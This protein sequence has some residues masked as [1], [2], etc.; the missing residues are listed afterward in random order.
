MRTR[1]GR[2]R[3]QALAIRLLL[4]TALVSFFD[5]AFAQAPPPASESD[6]ARAKELFFQGNELRKAGN[7]AGALELYLQSRELAPSVPNT[8]NAAVCLSELGRYDEALEMYERLLA[9]FRD[10][11]DPE[12]KK[13]IAEETARLRAK[14]GSV[15]VSSNVGG[16]LVIDGRPRGKLPLV[17]PVRVL[18]GTRSVRVIKSGYAPFSRDVPVTVGQTVRV[19]AALELLENAGLVK[20]DSVDLA[21][22]EI[23]IDGAR[24][25]R[26]PWE[27]MLQPG[28]H[29]AVIRKGDFG[30]A[31][32]RVTVVAGQTAKL[33]PALGALGP[34]LQIATQPT[35]ARL[36]IGD[37]D[38]GTG[39][40]TGRLPIG[41]IRVS[42]TDEGY[43]AMKEQLTITADGPRQRE[44]VLPIDDAHPRWRHTERYVWVELFGGPGIAPTVSS[45]A[46]ASC[47]QPR[48]ACSDT[49]LGLGFV[50]GARGGF[51]FPFR[52]SIEVAGGY[53]R[54]GQSLSRT[55][56]GMHEGQAITFSLDD[57][58]TIGGALAAAGLGYRLPVAEPFELSAHVLVG[59]FIATHQ[60]RIDASVSNGAT[61]I[62]AVVDQSGTRSTSPNLFVMPE[63]RAGLRFGNV[64]IAATFGATVFALDG[65]DSEHGALGVD[66][67]TCPR[68]DP[69]SLNCIVRRGDVAKEKPS[70]TFVTFVPGL[71]V[72][73]AFPL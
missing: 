66:E 2:R 32:L 15:D 53:A 73:Y 12:N 19:D 61:T 49:S 30:T 44:L 51:E 52:L 47:E 33:A 64:S 40:W 70:G 69:G 36:R 60:H 6:L 37:V 39:S 4:L 1:S 22:A 11:L 27:G 21:G 24:V 45:D 46:E 28:E 57:E 9:E 38:V 10:E 63:L 65:P 48:F 31:P 13:I 34:E 3:W 16:Q 29:W 59:A 20:V 58:I 50:V 71:S 8:Q 42:A 62:P 55:L 5:F 17:A 7:W 68:D 14:T 54:L 35:S 67:S 25:G 43:L 72:G 26:A 23:Y 56:A 18:P 41:S